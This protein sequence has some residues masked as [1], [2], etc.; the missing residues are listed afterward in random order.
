[1]ARNYLKE[2][3]GDEINVLLSAV[4]MNFNRVINL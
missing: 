2:I 3:A 1:M 4:A